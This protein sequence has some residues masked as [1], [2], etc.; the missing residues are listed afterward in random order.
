MKNM[1]KNR[2]LAKAILEAGWGEFRRMIEY[3]AAWYG[4]TVVIVDRFFAWSKL[5][6][7][8]GAKKPMLTLSDRQWQCLACSAVHD[9]DL[10]AARD[11]LAEDLRILAG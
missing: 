2:K 6:G 1:V 10:N 4:R 9:R 5:C 11:I 3:K 8:C 7:E